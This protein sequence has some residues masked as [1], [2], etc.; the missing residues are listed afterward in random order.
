[1]AW[2]DVFAHWLHLTAAI[3]WVGGTLFTSLVVQP[4][5]RAELSDDRRF[6]VYAGIGRRLSVVQWTTW[7]VLLA[8]G[9]WKLWGVRATPEVFHGPFG[10]ILG[11]KLAL[12]AVMV[13]L[14]LAHSL[15][16]GPALIQGKLA[17]AQRGVIARRMAFWGRVNALVLLA[18]VFCAVLL[19]YNPW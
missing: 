4:V 1:M 19:R 8:T 3:V 16:W 15:S 9:L 11:V 13:G 14:S 2:V 12:V 5:L 7:S 17:P 18:I 6:V 10:R